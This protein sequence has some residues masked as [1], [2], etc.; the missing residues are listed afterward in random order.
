[1]RS[2]GVL[3]ATGRLAGVISQS[4]ISV[5]AAGE[6]KCPA[7]MRVS[8]IMSRDLVVVRPEMP[9]DEYLV[10]LEEPDAFLG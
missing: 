7:W 3:D 6:N 10:V 4:D 9:L 1:V 5:K 2:V 8:E